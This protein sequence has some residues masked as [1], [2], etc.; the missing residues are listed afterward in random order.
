MVT[1]TGFEPMNACVKGMCVEPLHQRAKEM[2]GLNR[3]ELSTSRLSGVRSNQLS[4]RPMHTLFFDDYFIIYYFFLFSNTFF[5]FFLFF[6]HFFVFPLFFNKK[7][8]TKSCYL[9]SKPKF[10]I[11]VCILIISKFLSDIIFL[12]LDGSAVKSYAYAKLTEELFC[13]TSIV[14]LSYSAF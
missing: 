12:G 6:L 11:F 9:H 13:L 14:M 8:A 4:Y 2:V 5:E 3:L 7:I 10:C 1:R